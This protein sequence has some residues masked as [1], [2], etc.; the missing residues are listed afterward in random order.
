MK[1]LL[2]LALILSLL[3]S[4]GVFASPDAVVSESADEALA[5]V[6]GVE[7]TAEL[8]ME[9]TVIN[10]DFSKITEVPSGISVPA[11]WNPTITG[12]ALQI[13][14]PAAWNY[15][16][17]VSF[18][19]EDGATYKISAKIKSNAANSFF[20]V[21]AGSKQDTTNKLIQWTKATTTTITDKT[22][23]VN[24]NNFPELR[25][26]TAVYISAAERSRLMI[27]IH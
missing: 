25:F 8:A 5:E 13:T 24:S 18:I 19:L 20:L 26:T 14:S 11:N 4:C 16:A 1:K 7:E 23:T 9:E 15:G 2:S 27:F 17:V 21:G 10:Y 3:L 12:G 22:Y 6:S